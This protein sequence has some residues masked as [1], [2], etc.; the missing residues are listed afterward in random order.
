MRRAR[1]ES[2]VGQRFG[3]LVVLRREGRHRK[4][5]VWRCACD[6]GKECVARSDRLRHGRKKACGISGHHWKEYLKDRPPSFTTQHPDEYASWR[7]MHERCADK[8]RHNYKNYGARDIKVCERWKVFENF[9]I[10]LGP[11]PTKVHT[12][13]RVDNDGNYEP[14]NCRWATREEQRRNMTCSV[15]VE[16]NGQRRLLMDVVAEI[17]VK[18]AVVSGRLK[19]GWPLDKA[20]LTPVREKKPRLTKR[21]TTD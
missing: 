15:Y 1:A 5:A 11:K 8:H 18:R 9:F 7:K 16:H 4:Y 19:M 10:D 20:L 12:L 21:N 2:L 17:G 6:C 14:T 13:E 3:Y